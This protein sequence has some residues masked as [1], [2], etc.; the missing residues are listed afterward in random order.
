ME[1]IRQLTDYVIRE[2]QNVYNFIHN[3]YE[4]ID[5]ISIKIGKIIKL[6]NKDSDEEKIYGFGVASV[7]I[8]SNNMEVIATPLRGIQGRFELPKENSLVYLFPDESGKY[9]YVS[10]KIDPIE[11]VQ[12]S[13]EIGFKGSSN[14][15]VLPNAGEFFNKVREKKDKFRILESSKNFVLYEDKDE[16]KLG[17]DL[18]DLNN[19]EISLG[20]SGRFIIKR[21][22]GVTKIDI[23]FDIG[24][25]GSFEIEGG[26]GSNFKINIGTS[27]L[28]IEN[29]KIKIKTN[30][31]NSEGDWEHE[32]KIEVSKTGHFGEDITWG[33]PKTKASTHIHPT[34][35]GPSSKPNVGS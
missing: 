9:Y 22:S 23:K 14:I 10:G 2:F 7:L 20:N 17:L 25:L 15:K 33:S 12:S 27:S 35:T 4:R 26:L 32:G 16:K 24:S 3:L 13:E 30:Q 8:F 31:I 29:N 18:D 34:P 11:L 1:E 28:E 21:L 5:I 6:F 19:F